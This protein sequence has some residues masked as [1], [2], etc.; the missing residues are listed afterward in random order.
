MSLT[1]RLYPGG[2][3]YKT[4][5]GQAL[6]PLMFD[7]IFFGGGGRIK[8]KKVDTDEERETR[9]HQIKSNQ[10]S[11]QICLIILIDVFVCVCGGESRSGKTQTDMDNLI[12]RYTYQ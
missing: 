12:Y 5:I 7:G 8:R 1:S 6:L 10:I 3:G 9:F 2:I 4:E 11:V